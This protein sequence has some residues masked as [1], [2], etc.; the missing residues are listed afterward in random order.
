MQLDDTQQCPWESWY[1]VGILAVQQTR[2]QTNWERR[3]Q[4]YAGESLETFSDG[5][6]IA[7]LASHAPESIRN[8]GQIG[9]GPA[10]G[11]YRAVRQNMSEFLQFGR[12]FDKDGR[13]VESE[14]SSANATPMDVDGVG[15]GKGKGCF[16]SGPRSERLQVQLSQ[17]QG[18]RQRKD[19]EYLD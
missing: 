11:N 19:K 12:I 4:E 17:G 13:R 15:K 8:V 7:V 1:L 18:P 2:F 9:S 3:I 16:V 5:M 10:N 14:P 6:K